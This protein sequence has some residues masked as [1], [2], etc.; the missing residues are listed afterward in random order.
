[1]AREVYVSPSDVLCLA[2]SHFAVGEKANKACAILRLSRARIAG[3]VDKPYELFAG[4]KLQSFL[5]DL[6]PRKPRGRIVESRTGANCLI[7]DR[8][9]RAYAVLTTL[10]A[11]CCWY[12]LSQAS[13]SR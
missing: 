1:M 9:Q 5:A 6:H 10:G 7:E 11:Y 4:R 13:Q 3:L 2:D 8:T 12:R